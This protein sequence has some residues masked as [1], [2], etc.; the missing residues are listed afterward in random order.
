MG[1][2]HKSAT[3]RTT[4]SKTKRKS[5]PHNVISF[6]LTSFDAEGAHFEA[7]MAALSLDD[8]S[9]NDVCDDGTAAENESVTSNVD[10]RAKGLNCLHYVH[11]PEGFKCLGGDDQSTAL[12]A[13]LDQERVSLL[14]SVQHIGNTVP[15][16]SIVRLLH[17]WATQEVLDGNN[18][19]HCEHCAKR[20]AEQASNASNQ[21]DVDAPLDG[22]KR[23]VSYYLGSGATS[24]VEDIAAREEDD[25]R[26]PDSLSHTERAVKQCRI[27]QACAHSEACALS[28][29]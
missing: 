1:K 9:D 11:A 10:V 28:C 12:Q 15:Q 19:F 18:A 27:T 14:G 6:P 20:A 13:Q 29:I 7:M 8:D 23:A 2:A 26:L 16:G 25:E 24:R 4:R 17:G 21:G 3:I 22:L 5:D